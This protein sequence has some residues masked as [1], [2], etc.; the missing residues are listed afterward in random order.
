MKVTYTKERMREEW[1][2][3]RWLEPLRADC[4]IR[5]SDGIDLDAYAETEMRQ[6]YL[7]LLATAPAGLLAP[8]DLTL[9]STVKRTAS[10]TAYVEL[11][12]TVVRVVSVRLAGWQRDAM[13][14]SGPH[15]PLAMRQAN[16]FARGGVEHPVAVVN[17]HRLE[18]YSAANPDSTPMLESLLVITDTGSETYKFDERAWL[19]VERAG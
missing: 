13:I 3:R 19:L 6:W 14:A 15:D 12:D 17:G 2:K 10:G 5:R 7:E 4:R 16:R 9:T 11:P 1:K 18:L 8:T